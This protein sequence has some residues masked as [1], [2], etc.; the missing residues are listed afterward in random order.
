MIKMNTRTNEDGSVS[1]LQLGGRVDAYEATTVKSWLDQKTTRK[2]A[3]VVVNL[4]DVNF[5]DS[6]GLATFVQGMKHCRNH[7]GDMH[8]CGLQQQVRLI[9]ELTRLDLAFKIFL[10]EEEAVEA[11]KN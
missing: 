11:F 3:Q 9:F 4:S 7:E 6:T 8:I 2:P 1:I 10:K 5:I